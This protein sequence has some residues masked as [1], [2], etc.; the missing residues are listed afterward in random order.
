[1]R[2]SLEAAMGPIFV[3]IWSTGFIIA[4][5]SMP[6][7]EPA[8]FLLWR[9]MGVLLA[10]GILSLIWRPVWPKWPLAGHIGVAG[11]LLQFGYLLGVWCAVRFGMSAGLAALI[12]GLQPILT[13]WWSAWVAEHVTQ[14]QWLGLALGFIGVAFVVFEKTHFVQLPLASYLLIIGALLSITLGTLYQKKF[15]ANFDLRAG[16][17]IQFA[18]AVVLTAITVALFETG[19]MVWNWPV[20]IALGWSIGPLSIGSVSLL[21]LLIR[22]G[23]AT[24]VTSLLYL[25]PPTTAVM[26]WIGF[27]EPLTALMIFGI[28]LTMVGVLIVNHKA[29][30]SLP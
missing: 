3:L 16:S 19:K 22:K 28:L 29:Q 20:V 26:A 7:V 30:V 2:F 18:V 12:V 17:L 5:L 24:R 9:F 10:M 23:T 11:A 14:R 27:H 25:T 8:T 21:F 6:Y 13:A 15:C 4:R 1:M